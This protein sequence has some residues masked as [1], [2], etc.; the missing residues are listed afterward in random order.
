MRIE[1]PGYKILQLDTLLLDYNGTVA[2]DG[3]IP[4]S[5]R[6]R[7]ASL[8]EEFKIYILTADTHGTAAKQCQDN[9]ILKI[10][11]Q[12]DISIQNRKF[13]NDVLTE[14]FY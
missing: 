8:S 5:V 14:E 2:L 3:Q 12:K 7:L 10:S 9:L 1:I 13:I 6:E 4:L 11:F